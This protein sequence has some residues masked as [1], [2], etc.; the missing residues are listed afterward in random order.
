MGVGDGSLVAL[1]LERSLDLVVAILGVLKAGGA[2]VPLDPAYPAER[3]AFALEDTAASVLLTQE[4]L[5][6]GLPAHQAEVVCLDRDAELMRDLPAENPESVSSP[7]SAAYV[8]YTSGS[9]GR[10]K[11][12]TV[13]HRNVARLFTATDDW[14]GFGPKD[15]W[16]LLHSY[17]FDF[18]VW[19]LWGALL[20]GGR[21]VVVSPLTTRCSPGRAIVAEQVTVLNATPS[22]FMTRSTISWR[23]RAWSL[24]LVVFGGEALQPAA[25]RPWFERLGSPGPLVNMYGI[26]ELQSRH[27]PSSDGGRL[28]PRRQPDR[29]A[30]PTSKPTSWTAASSPSPKAYPASF[31]SAAPGSPA[32]TST[33]PN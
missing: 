7:E 15:T 26:T 13:E 11:G 23:R 33:G 25:L 9:T 5:L 12:V 20:Y 17:A 14:F 21:L 31:S 27:L 30:I 16:L 6:D 29:A 22:L 4:H 28:R 19:E 32:A 10:P 3:L 1:C 24:R 2:Y 8:I 18:S